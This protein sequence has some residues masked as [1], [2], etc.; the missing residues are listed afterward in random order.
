M[1]QALHLHYRSGNFFNFLIFF[2]DQKFK[3]LY[4]AVDRNKD[5]S[6]S[7]DELYSILYPE[8]A[9]EEDILVLFYF[10]FM[11]SSRLETERES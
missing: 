11:T 7:I 2:S 6:I 5:G 8:K 1:L 4:K 3:R 10:G 9:E